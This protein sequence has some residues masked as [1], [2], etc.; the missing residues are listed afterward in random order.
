MGKNTSLLLQVKRKDDIP[1]KLT[2]F[3]LNVLMLQKPQSVFSEHFNEE[4]DID[5]EHVKFTEVLKICI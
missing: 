4:C 2:Q 1:S 5:N 3:I